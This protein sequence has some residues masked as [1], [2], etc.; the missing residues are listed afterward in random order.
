MSPAE[1]DLLGPLL[2]AL[3]ETVLMPERWPDALRLVAESFGASGAA[4]GHTA[5]DGDVLAL[6]GHGHDEAAQ[7]LYLRHYHALDPAVPVALRA[8]AG[9]WIADA[10]A[11]DARSP[12]QAE[13]VHDFALPHGI[14]GVAGGKVVQTDAHTI[15][16]G[17]Q[18]RPDSPAFGTGGAERFLQLVPHLRLV[19]GLEQ[20]VAGLGLERAL[21]QAALDRLR[22]ALLVA[23]GRG[24]VR[25]FNRAAEALLA[26]RV[27]R[28]VNGRLAALA[29]AMHER[30][31][32]LLRQACAEHPRAGGLMLPQPDGRPALLLNVIPLP[33]RHAMAA[34]ALTPLA[35]VMIGD[36]SQP[37][38][39]AGL[40]REMFG[41]T[42]AEAE[43]MHALANGV[44]VT[45]YA[46]RRL[47][48]VTTVRSQLRSV[49]GKC[50]CD[51]QA[52]L[53]ALARSLPEAD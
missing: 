52:R 51:T 1:D 47:V 36:P 37:A 39:R 22:A 5:A 38:A 3:Y 53:V 32:A 42:Q 18:R 2:A 25:L 50:G 6:R 16:L 28:L 30:L 33:V 40:L 45:E 44:Q 24:H 26:T 12:Y 14:G 41:L 20:R 27:V 9:R 43:L 29:P 31:Q 35:L 21:A 4:I 7:A 11:W 19:A 13:Y 34:Q 8:A 15:W 46:Q 17:L 10:E 48:S 49:M 23:D